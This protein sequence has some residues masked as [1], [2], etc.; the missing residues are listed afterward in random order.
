V[1]SLLHPHALYVR[2]IG[3]LARAGCLGYPARSHGEQM[4]GWQAGKAIP[5]D[6]SS[7]VTVSVDSLDWYV[8]LDIGIWMI[9]FTHGL[10]VF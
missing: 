9:R 6:A 2:V 7:H 1:S 3:Y 10:G 5:D 4:S 8:Q